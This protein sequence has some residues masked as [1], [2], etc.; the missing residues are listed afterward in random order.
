M[1]EST[2]T[3][4]RTYRKPTLKKR[5]QLQ[6]VTEFCSLSTGISPE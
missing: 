6:E 2:K 1:A 4:E 3:D 5:E